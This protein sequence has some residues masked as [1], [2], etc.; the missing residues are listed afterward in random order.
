MVSVIIP[1][2]NVEKYL[3]NCLN[4]IINQT[5]KDIEIILIDDGS[6]DSSGDI[7]D[8][9]AAKDQRIK[10]IHKEN[11]GVSSA[12]NIGLSLATGEYIGFVDSDDYIHKDYFEILLRGISKINCDLSI[13]S[14]KT[15]EGYSNIND[16]M[17]QFTED[18]FQIFDKDQTF[19]ELLNNKKIYGYLWNKLFKKEL[20]IEHFNEEIHFAEDF[21]FCSEYV[22]NIKGAI[23][24]DCPVYY[25]RQNRIG[26]ISS[27]ILHYDDKKFSLLL[28][29]TEIIKIYEDNARQHLFTFYNIILDNALNLL[30][31]YK[32]NKIRNNEQLNII[33]KSIEKYYKVCIKKFN[34]SKRVR[35]FIRKNFT[36]AYFKHQYRLIIKRK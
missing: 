12:R 36:Y 5:Y 27:G 23:F 7:C 29:Q 1:V 30:G 19:G 31:K 13:C 8:V 14:M 16:E 20:I 17:L 32:Y 15:F 28:A 35:Y 22:K 34:F 11:G 26:S 25:Y 33:K 10:V 4:S 9:Y 2:Y 24:I 21:L 3:E 6:T 18:D